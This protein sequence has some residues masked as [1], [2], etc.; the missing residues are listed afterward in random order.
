MRRV[1]TI[2]VTL[3]VVAAGVSGC[4][5]AHGSREAFCEQ[6]RKTPA[7]ATA[8]AGYP[9]GDAATYAKQLRQARQAFGDLQKAA[10]RSIRA[11]V[12][13]VGEL[14]NDIVKA[15]EQHPDD[16]AGVASALRMRM[17]SSPSAAKAAV[18]VGNYAS[19]ECGIKLGSLPETPSTF[20]L[21]RTSVPMSPTTGG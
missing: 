8:L 20:E 15:I 10:P 4:A 6:L 18:N 19:K 7:L 3:V 21:P 13:S 16:P 9:S 2:V 14:V 11:D 1:A 17:M 5:K 12:G